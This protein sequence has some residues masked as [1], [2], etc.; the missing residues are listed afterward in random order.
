MA[1]TIDYEVFTITHLEVKDK[2][3]L[4]TMRVYGVIDGEVI[5]YLTTLVAPERIDT[6][7][8]LSIHIFKS[9]LQPKIKEVYGSHEPVVMPE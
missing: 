7:T 6:P 4:V 2:P 3:T 5:D 1:D 9:V 8:R